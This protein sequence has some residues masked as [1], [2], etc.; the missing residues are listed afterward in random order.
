MDAQVAAALLKDFAPGEVGHKPAPYCKAC[1]AAVRNRV[2]KSCGDHKVSYCK[3]CRTTLTEAH[4]CLDFVGHADVRHRLCEADP[5]WT[6]V[7]YEFPGTGAIVMDGDSPVGLWITLT[8]GGVSKP[9]YGSC[10]KGKGDAMKELI[11][12]A[13]RNA[14]QSFGI[15]WKMWAKSERGQSGP[16][17]GQGASSN[18]ESFDN[19]T[20]APPRSRVQKPQAKAAAAPE[21]TAPATAPGE[22]DIDA[23]AFA[24][25][26]SQCRTTGSLK[27]VNDRARE[28]AKLATQIRNPATGGTGA[29][30]KYIEWRRVQITD[31]EAAL[32]ELQQA[33][34]GAHVPWDALD[35]RVLHI[36]GADI[37]G[38]TAAQLRETA[39]SLALAGA[40]A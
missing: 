16:A 30:G 11:G 12:D 5:D 29:L 39:K 27:A 17:Q 33:A 38:A 15:A 19:A 3:K 32:R 6:W 13:I 28:A 35:A 23:Q 2:A 22:P 14:G 40:T 36:T 8:V 37:E 26:A 25:E 34:D 10:D 4:T 18:A 9:G 24:D 7:P 1:N 20:P 31:T 21:P